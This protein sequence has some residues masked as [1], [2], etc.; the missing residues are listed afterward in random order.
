MTEKELFAKKANDG[1]TVCYAEQCPRREQCLRWKV[2]RQMPDSKS[3]YTMVNPRSQGVGTAECPHYRTVEKVKFAK[4]MMHIFN[5]DMPRRVTE[6]VR[7]G[8]IG[9]CCKT[10]YYE[11]RKGQRLIPPA[12]QEEIRSLF[13]K[14]GWEKEIEF[15]GY[16]EDYEW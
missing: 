13:L 10:Y 16:V 3:F 11:Y 1:Y 4:G 9:S 14:A 12:I 2:G 15:D 5:D 8:I 6:T 7:M